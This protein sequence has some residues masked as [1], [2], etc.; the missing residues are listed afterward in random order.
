MS[1]TVIIP[2][3]DLEPELHRLWAVGG[4]D[5]LPFPATYQSFNPY[6]GEVICCP[7]YLV[8]KDWAIENGYWADVARPG[9]EAKAGDD[10]E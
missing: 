1:D 4:I 6:S 5:K 2:Q 7:G 9:G 8:P 3:G 10:G